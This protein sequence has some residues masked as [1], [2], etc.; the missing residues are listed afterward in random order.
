MKDGGKRFVKDLL[1]TGLASLIVILLSALIGPWVLL[2]LAMPLNEMAIKIGTWLP[3]Q[4]GW[5]EGMANYVLAIDVIAFFEVWIAFLI[6]M[7]LVRLQI[8]RRE[9]HDAVSLHLK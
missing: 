8:N 5:F 4:G 6:L 3:S 9:K 2:L 1:A 7:G